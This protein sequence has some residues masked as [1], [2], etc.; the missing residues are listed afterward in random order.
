MRKAVQLGIQGNFPDVP[1]LPSVIAYFVVSYWFTSD[2]DRVLDKIGKYLTPF[3]AL[4]LI[5]IGI[6]GVISPIGVPVQA[7]VENAFVNAFLGGYN[8][9]DVLVS[10]IMAAV[11]IQSV[12]NK[13]YEDNRSRNK[14]M[15]ACSIVTVILLFIIYGSLLYMGACVS[16]EFSSDMGRADLLVAI[17]R[18][19]GKFVMIPM[20]IAI[21]LACL[22]T[23]VGQVAAVADFFRT[24]SKE[25]LDYKTLVIGTCILRPLQRSSA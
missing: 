24:A 17:I 7:S 8:T 19:V 15:I 14:M 22:T 9:G 4:I 20:G 25:K 12:R 23:A 13:G 6:V 2:E 5:V 21:I 18:H 3:L 16:G 11:F 1:F 10:F